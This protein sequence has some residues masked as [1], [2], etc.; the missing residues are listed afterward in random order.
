M[1]SDGQEVP[2]KVAITDSVG[3]P[4]LSKTLLQRYTAITPAADNFSNVSVGVR[5][6]S[7]PRTTPLV[8]AR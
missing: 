4:V 6:E 2:A 7:T 3:T 1:I 5:L 8:H